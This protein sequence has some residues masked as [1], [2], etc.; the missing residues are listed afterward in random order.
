[1][2][3]INPFSE[4]VIASTRM[5]GNGIMN[6]KYSNGN[7]ASRAAAVPLSNNSAPV[8]TNGYDAN[9]RIEMSKVRPTR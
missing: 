8:T 3:A 5:P 9:S 1:M 6:T 7:H 2:L 4:P